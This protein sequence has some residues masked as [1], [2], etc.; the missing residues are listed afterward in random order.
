MRQAAIWSELLHSNIRKFY[1]AY[2]VGRASF[3]HEPGRRLAE[4]S[5]VTWEDLL[6]CAR[7]LHY[8][9]E[10]GIVHQNLSENHLLY[11]NFYRR[12][13]LSGLDLVGLGA[14]GTNTR[15]QVLDIRAFGCVIFKLR[16]FKVGDQLPEVRPE[17]VLEDE[18][19]LLTAM[20][21]ADASTMEEVLYKIG[22]LAQREMSSPH[23]SERVQ[24]AKVVGDLSC[25]EIQTLGQSIV[26]TLDDIEALCNELEEFSNVNRP[27]CARLKDVYEQ[28]DASQAPLPVALVENFALIVLHFYD[29]LDQRTLG[30]ISSVST[31]LASKTLA[32]KMYGLHQD[33]DHLLRSAPCL[34]GHAKSI[35]GGRSF[36]R[37]AHVKIKSY[38]RRLPNH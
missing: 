6:G 38:E 30:I 12:G 33:I 25:Y 24:S 7:G 29:M 32:G 31:L 21:T 26:T 27:V 11:S 20:C 23:D 15:G 19:E 34:D 28:L 1:G 5:V 9:H 35:A 36:K 8:L 3:I 13:F 2:Y 4:K 37:P 17:F 10:R 18:W 22:V 14:K 16:Y